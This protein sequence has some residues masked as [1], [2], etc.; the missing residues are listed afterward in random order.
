MHIQEHLM[1]QLVQARESILKQIIDQLSIDKDYE[2]CAKKMHF[3]KHEGF[4][5]REWIA[6]NDQIIGEIVMTQGY[7]DDK[8]SYQMDWEFRPCSIIK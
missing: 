7:D 5:G 4:P 8:R 1:T 2:G 3:I 6:Y